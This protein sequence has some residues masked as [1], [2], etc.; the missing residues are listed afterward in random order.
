MILVVTFCTIGAVV[1]SKTISPQVF[2]MTS[3]T[4]RQ[5]ILTKKP[6]KS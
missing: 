3:N 6:G 5:M 1:M 2:V 4:A